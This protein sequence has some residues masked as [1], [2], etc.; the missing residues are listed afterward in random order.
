[1]STK[2][3]KKGGSMRNIYY[4]IEQLLAGENPFKDTDIPLIPKK[5]EKETRPRFYFGKDSQLNGRVSKGN[6]TSH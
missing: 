3:E 4:S 2:V 6:N 5:D 1:M